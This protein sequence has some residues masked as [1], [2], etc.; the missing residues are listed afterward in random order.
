MRVWCLTCSARGVV[1][2]ANAAANALARVGEGVRP[3][4]AY[5]RLPRAMAT[6][7]GA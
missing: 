3:T 4:G 6:C 1:G 7:L 2:Q 5:G